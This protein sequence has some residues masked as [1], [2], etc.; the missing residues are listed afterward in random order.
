MTT[1][2]LHERGE[3]TVRHLV[4]GSSGI[5]RGPVEESLAKVGSTEREQRLILLVRHRI[6]PG[7]QRIAVRLSELRLK[8]AAILHLNDVPASCCELRLPLSRPDA[9]DHPVE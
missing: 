9:R 1:Q 2:V 3:V 7:S 4:N 8:P 5:L 6:N